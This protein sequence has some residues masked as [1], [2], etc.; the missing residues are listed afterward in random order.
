M[1]RRKLASRE[2]LLKY[3]VGVR[4]DEK[5]YNKLKTWVEQTNASSVG[6]LVRKIITKEKVTFYVRDISM[7]DSTAELIRIR[8]EINAIGVNINQL[9]QEYHSA[10]S[11]EQRLSPALKIHE[12]Y[13]KVTDKVNEVWKEVNEMSRKWSAR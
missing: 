6:E 3:K 5:T 13:Q 1:T 9:T 11:F 2:E 7:E 12:L 8:K 10:N 4:F